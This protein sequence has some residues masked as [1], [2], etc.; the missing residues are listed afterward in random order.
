MFEKDENYYPGGYNQEPQEPTMADMAGNAASNASYYAGMAA[1]S[2]KN[3][4]KKMIPLVIIGIIILAIIGGVFWWLGQN[5][6]ITFNVKGIDTLEIENAKITITSDNK[7]IYSGSG[8]THT[9]A[10]QPGT[11]VVRV[12]AENYTT[13]TMNLQIPNE[14]KG[15]RISNISVEMKRKIKADLEIEFDQE[16]MFPSETLEGIIKITN[17]SDEI[18]QEQPIIIKDA[19]GLEF[20]LTPEKFSVSAGG[21]TS[22]LFEVKQ[23][24]AVTEQKIVNPKISIKDTIIKDDFKLTLMPYVL[25]K[26]IIFSGDIRNEK[27]EKTSLEA[28]KRVSVTFTI[29]NKNKKVP[30]ENLIINITPL[31]SDYEDKIDWFEFTQYTQEKN[32]YI[33]PSIE[34][35]SKKPITFE[36]T[37]PVNTTIADGEFKGTLTISS[38]SMQNERTFSIYIKVTKERKVGLALQSLKTLKINC[39]ELTG[40][41]SKISSSEIGSLKNI[42]TE[43][44][45]GISKIEINQ[46]KSATECEWLT[47]TPTS[48]DSL[49]PTDTAKKIF[50]EINP[51]L[52]TEE[53]F[54]CYLRWEYPDP[55]NT[56]DKVIE[57]SDP[58]K[59]EIT[60]N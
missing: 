45:T 27:I 58:I 53:R 46:S 19:T 37:P 4:A 3:A 35:D 32:T 54:Y 10:L 23:K 2:G 1:D 39:D 22:I 57:L 11:Y 8:G 49:K 51:G 43:T 21:A 24:T 30:L 33:I 50:A 42:G 20:K 13:E 38:L 16:K 28:G 36:I 31:N 44:I 40:A 9:V 34:A 47:I 25:N 14:E 7:P 55:L 41:C 59:I 52:T 6:T 26:D 12:L 48:I 15:E 56:G 5:Q 60:T 17:T 18:I 29:E